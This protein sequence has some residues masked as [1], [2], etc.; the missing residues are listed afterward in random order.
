MTDVKPVRHVGLADAEHPVNAIARLKVGE[1]V[2]W[3]GDA[4]RRARVSRWERDFTVTLADKAGNESFVEVPF[5]PPE[6]SGWRVDDAWRVAERWL[7]MG[8]RE[9]RRTL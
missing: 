4:G 6:M 8:V 1:D 2:A 3:E 7:A 5:F 9:G